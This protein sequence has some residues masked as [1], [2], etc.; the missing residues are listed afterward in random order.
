MCLCSLLWLKVWLVWFLMLVVIAKYSS[1]K[2]PVAGGTGTWGERY[3]RWNCELWNGRWWWHL[4]AL[5]DW[6]HHRSPQ[7]SYIFFFFSFIICRFVTCLIVFKKHLT[8]CPKDQSF[9]LVSVWDIVS[10]VCCT[11]RYRFVC[12]PMRRLFMKVG[13][14]SWSSSVTKITLRNPQLSGSIH[15]STWLVSTMKLEW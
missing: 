11:N 12:P 6:H 9:V 5:L 10:F 3:W 4:H 14:I 15:V 8:R 13:S 7:R 2:L 1:E